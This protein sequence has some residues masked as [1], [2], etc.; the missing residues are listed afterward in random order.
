M[1]ETY[2][3]DVG[4]TMENTQTQLWPCKLIASSC[5]TRN[6]FYNM[7]IEP[8]QKSHYIQFDNFNKFLDETKIN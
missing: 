4:L 1:R 3:V 7:Q 6:H 5:P 8:G 2:I